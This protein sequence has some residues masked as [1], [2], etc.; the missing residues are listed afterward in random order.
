MCLAHPGGDW[1][2]INPATVFTGHNAFQPGCQMSQSFKMSEQ[3][4]MSELTQE[5]VI[6]Y[7]DIAH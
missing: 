4:N 5:E 1:L 3:A 7:R 2:I 6:K